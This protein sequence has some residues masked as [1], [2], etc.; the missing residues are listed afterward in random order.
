MF[1]NESFLYDNPI[2]DRTYSAM[3]MTD[4][5]TVYSLGTELGL[6]ETIA[7]I[8]Q[9]EDC[10]L[11]FWQAREKEFLRKIDK[12]RYLA[13]RHELHSIDLSFI[14]WGNDYAELLDGES[15]YLLRQE[16]DDQQRIFISNPRALQDP[17]FQP[18]AESLDTWMKQVRKLV[19]RSWW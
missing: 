17:R 14:K 18:L 10:W 7:S 13:L 9:R 6:E 12:Q 19:K 1:N 11:A 5:S 16:G 8:G 15:Y 3:L 4:C 2:F